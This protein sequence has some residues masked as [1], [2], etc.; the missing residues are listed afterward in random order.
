LLLAGVELVGLGVQLFG[1]GDAA[2]LP[3]FADVID[4][5]DPAVE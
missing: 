3:E 4:V 1:L 2:V 5:R